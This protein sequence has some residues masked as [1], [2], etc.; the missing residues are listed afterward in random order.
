MAR[1]GR[2]EFIREFLIRN[3]IDPLLIAFKIDRTV[4]YLILA[5]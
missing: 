3:N 5:P 1:Q 4:R 2:R